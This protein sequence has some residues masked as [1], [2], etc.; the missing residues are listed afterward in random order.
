M[1]LGMPAAHTRG[2]PA[3]AGMPERRRSCWHWASVPLKGP[4]GTQVS[5]RAKGGREWVKQVTG[6]NEGKR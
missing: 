6:K 3:H 4:A 2:M 1:P 5:I